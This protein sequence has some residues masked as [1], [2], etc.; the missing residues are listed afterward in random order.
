MFWEH[1][2]HA[3]K[4]YSCTKN[5]DGASLFIVSQIFSQPKLLS[6]FLTSALLVGKTLE[7]RTFLFDSTKIGNNSITAP[8]SS[9]KA[10]KTFLLKLQKTETFLII[11]FEYKGNVLSQ[12]RREC[13]ESFQNRKH[14]APFLVLISRGKENDS[15]APPHDGCANP[16]VL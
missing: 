4:I 13:Q 9:G 14:F 3:E 5:K 2:I 11:G 8:P 10:I 15:S 7:R 6:L 16:K 1:L 12:S